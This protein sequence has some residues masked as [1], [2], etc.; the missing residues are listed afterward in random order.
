METGGESLP[1]WILLRVSFFF[2]GQGLPSRYCGGSPL[3]GLALPTTFLERDP[4]RRLLSLE[5][6]A[7]L[8]L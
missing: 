2:A 1:E 4:Q 7:A 6:I 5:G 8:A 3:V